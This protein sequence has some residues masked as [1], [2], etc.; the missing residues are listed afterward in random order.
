MHELRS[1]PH[2]AE[3]GTLLAHAVAQSIVESS[4]HACSPRA[5]VSDSRTRNNCQLE[6]LGWAKWR[7]RNPSLAR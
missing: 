3:R 2:E 5:G 6:V 1:N 4:F 7:S